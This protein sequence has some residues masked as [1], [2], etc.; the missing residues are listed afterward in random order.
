[1]P[2]SND[3]GLVSSV[4]NGDSVDDDVVDNEDI[5]LLCEVILIDSS[6]FSIKWERSTLAGAVLTFGEG[7]FGDEEEANTK[8]REVSVPERTTCALRQ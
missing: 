7:S 5:V 4:I 8:L 1:M 6:R 3:I 2:T